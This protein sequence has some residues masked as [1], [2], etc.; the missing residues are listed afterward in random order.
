MQV[1]CYLW[2]DG[3]HCS[4]LLWPVC[5]VCVVLAHWFAG[6]HRSL[7][8]FPQAFDGSCIGWRRCCPWPDGLH[9]ELR[10]LAPIHNARDPV[11]IFIACSQVLTDPACVDPNKEAKRKKSKSKMTLGALKSSICRC[12]LRALNICCRRERFFL[13]RQSLHS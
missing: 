5:E 1:L 4:N 6:R 12:E 9:A 8:T 13:G 10:K 2:H 7:G 11:M 3:Q